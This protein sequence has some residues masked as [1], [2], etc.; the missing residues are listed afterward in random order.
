MTAFIGLGSSFGAY[1]L[2]AALEDG[3]DSLDLAVVL[4]ELESLLLS[5]LEELLLLLD[6]FDVELLLFL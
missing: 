5:L 4:L 2:L 1:S 6:P 3:L